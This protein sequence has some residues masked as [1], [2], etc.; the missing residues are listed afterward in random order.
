MQK[1]S[2]AYSLSEPIPCQSTHP[3]IAIALHL[4]Q[5][6]MHAG[7]GQEE[8]CYGGKKHGQTVF[9]LKKQTNIL[10]FWAN[11]VFFGHDYLQVLY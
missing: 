8:N 1:V 9:A 10:F 11:P 7:F 3:F 4:P 5:L 2:K 6:P